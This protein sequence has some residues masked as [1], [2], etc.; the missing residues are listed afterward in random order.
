MAMQITSAIKKSD[1]LKL[2]EANNSA[3]QIPKIL[4]H[5]SRKP[6]LAASTRFL[7]PCSSTEP[8]LVTLTPEKPV[9][10]ITA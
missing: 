8:T 10:Q 1:P 2:A 5:D 4:Q 9:A 6:T 3:D 7:V